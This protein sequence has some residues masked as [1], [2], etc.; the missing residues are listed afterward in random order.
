MFPRGVLRHASFCSLHKWLDILE[1]YSDPHLLAIYIHAS[2]DKRHFITLMRSI[3]G[4][5]Q[6]CPTLFKIVKY[7]SKTIQIPTPEPYIMLLL[8]IRHTL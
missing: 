7:I 5:A 3:T 4:R 8:I 1:S 6:T 2:Y